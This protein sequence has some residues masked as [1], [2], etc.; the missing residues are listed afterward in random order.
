MDDVLLVVEGFDA[1]RAIFLAL[2]LTI[3]GEATVKGPEVCG[4]EG[5]I[6]GLDGQFGAA[7]EVTDAI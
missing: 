2:G 1:A 6:V 4:T 7:Q 5:I 3:K